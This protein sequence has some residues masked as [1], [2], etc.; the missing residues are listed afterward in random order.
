M[1]SHENKLGR[2][3]N[4]GKNSTWKEMG[5]TL[6]ATLSKWE[7][8]LKSIDF[9]GIERN[10]NKISLFSFHVHNLVPISFFGSNSLLV[11]KKNLKYQFFILAWTHLIS[12]VAEVTKTKSFLFSSQ[13][14]HIYSFFA[15]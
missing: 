4:F 7:E 10:W 9:N 12:V 14:H 1:T 15:K 11:E 2:I 8:N 13:F 3:E 6:E 5:K